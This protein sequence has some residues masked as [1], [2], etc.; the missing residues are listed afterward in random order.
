MKK[1]YFILFILL[2]TGMW[3]QQEPGKTLLLEGYYSGS[4]IVVKNPFL[5]SGKG[6]CAYQVKVNGDY[7]T[8]ETNSEM[9]VI[10]IDKQG[11][12]PGEFVKVEIT[13]FLSW[14]ENTAGH[15]EPG[16]FAQQGKSCSKGE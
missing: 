4:N 16:C 6:F 3:S 7:S 9:F 10:P 11:I 2:C 12:K 15:Y 13:H 8:A 14:L 5:T 1:I